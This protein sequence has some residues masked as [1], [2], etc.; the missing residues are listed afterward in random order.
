MWG[1][2]LNANRF[3]PTRSDDQLLSPRWNKLFTEGLNRPGLTKISPRT[4]ASSDSGETEGDGANSRS[5]DSPVKLKLDLTPAQSS[6]VGATSSS[7]SFFKRS[8]EAKKTRKLAIDEANSKRET[9]KSKAVSLNAPR[10]REEL[11][12]DEQDLAASEELPDGVLTAGRGV[13]GFLH[14]GR[15]E[16]HHG[17]ITPIGSPPLLDDVMMTT[18][19]LLEMVKRCWKVK[20]AAPGPGTKGYQFQNPELRKQLEGMQTSLR[21]LSS[22]K[23]LVTAIETEDRVSEAV[24]GMLSHRLSERLEW[25]Q[26]IEFYEMRLD[27]MGLVY[28]IVGRLAAARTKIACQKFS[29][30]GLHKQMLSVIPLM[31]KAEL[32]RTE[33]NIYAIFSLPAGKVYEGQYQMQLDLIKWLRAELLHERLGELEAGKDWACWALGELVMTI[34]HPK[35]HEFQSA[36]ITK[37]LHGMSLDE[38]QRALNKEWD[39]LFFDHIVGLFA[40][41][42][43]ENFLHPFRLAWNSLCQYSALQSSPEI[44][45]YRLAALAEKMASSPS[46]NPRTAQIDFF[47]GLFNYGG[48][49]RSKWRRYFRVLFS[50]CVG[51]LEADEL[52]AQTFSEPGLILEL[53]DSPSDAIAALNGL[54][55]WAKHRLREAETPPDWLLAQ[56]NARQEMYP[57]EQIISEVLALWTPLLDN[58]QSE[59]EELKEKLDILR[60][61]WDVLRKSTIFADIP[62]MS[63]R[64]CYEGLPT[65]TGKLVSNAALTRSKSQGSS[66]KPNEAVDEVDDGRFTEPSPQMAVKVSSRTLPLKRPLPASVSQQSLIL[67]TRKVVPECAWDQF[68]SV[69]SIHVLQEMKSPTEQKKKRRSSRKSMRMELPQRSR[70]DNDLIKRQRSARQKSSG[71]LTKTKEPE[72]DEAVKELKEMASMESLELALKQLEELKEETITDPKRQ[73]EHKRKSSARSARETRETKSEPLS[74]RVDR[75][76][77]VH[78]KTSKTSIKSLDRLSEEP[79][80]SGSVTPK[81]ARTSRESRSSSVEARKGHDIT[82]RSGSTNS[83]NSKTLPRSPKQS[84]S[85]PPSGPIEE[86]VIPMRTDMKDK[87]VKR[88]SERRCQS[89][90]EKEVTKVSYPQSGRSVSDKL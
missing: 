86:I 45:W 6:D 22:Y 61:Q 21:Q 88:K 19:D 38:S 1:S 17:P 27:M 66:P 56:M 49:E 11:S 16:E 83:N 58:L 24:F 44:G 60:S 81:R 43:L 70:T 72:L 15:P 54:L 48:L 18:T 71:R 62:I 63:L 10:H 34:R 25:P 31:R 23:G 26:T 73:K 7:T 90:R 33:Q 35:L 32:E 65:L 77:K 84:S 67:D 9:R 4:T 40:S 41:P 57:N 76:K 39:R 50:L 52:V 14:R 20:S 75:D 28:R 59:Q 30:S 87:R 47:I 64:H 8:R 13:R 37:A 55:T 36:A 2:R 42:K 69:Q 85:R 68:T 53:E 79:S 3:H 89:E 82:N 29:S 80:S 51:Q 46:E 5:K 74:P 12:I 78:R